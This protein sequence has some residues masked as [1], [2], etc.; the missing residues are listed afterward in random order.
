MRLPL[1]TLPV[2]RCVAE[3]QNLRA[4]AAA[5]HLTH[6]AV[7][8]QIK[9]LET[10][11]GFALFDRRGR[12]VVLNAAGE[13]LLRS[14]QPALGLLE[15]GMQAAAAVA[16]GTEQRLRITVLPSFAQ[17]WLL[18]RMGDWRAQHPHLALEIDASQNLVDLHRA[19]LHAAIRYGRGPWHGLESEPLLDA[20]LPWIVVGSPSAARRLLGAPP[21]AYTREPLLG[22]DELWHAWFKA[23]GVRA[24]V[25]PVA[26]FN[27]AGLLLQ[28][29]EQQIG[30][31]LTRELLAADALAAGKLV[32]LSPLSVPYEDTQTY[33]L[34]YRP[35][36]RDWPP[37]R[38]LRLWL[39]QELRAAQTKLRHMPESG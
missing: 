39:R 32:R 16:S 26:V 22:E 6:S 10:Q 15:D 28:A 17:R 9:T 18:P 3:M 24:Q 23:A 21:E 4:A 29:A 30:L 34:A 5:L 36:L 14:V 2:F 8:Q 25:K 7:S 13:A 20:P 31:A 1:S 38:A 12:G 11:L 35:E 33:H 19:G 37:L 27:D